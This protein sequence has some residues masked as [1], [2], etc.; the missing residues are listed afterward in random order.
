VDRR[1]PENQ[2]QK[3]EENQSEPDNNQLPSQNN[4]APQNTS[5]PMQPLLPPQGQGV[6]T[7]PTSAPAFQPPPPKDDLN[8]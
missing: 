6:F 1:A 8:G 4:F 3:P 7:A 2:Q 5:T